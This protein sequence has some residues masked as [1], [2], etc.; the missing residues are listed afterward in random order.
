MNSLVVVTLLVV[1]VNAL[2]VVEEFFLVELFVVVF[3]V[4]VEMTAST[5]PSALG[6]A[7]RLGAAAAAR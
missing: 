3:E 2:V 4:L 6:W 7:A 5:S 1:L